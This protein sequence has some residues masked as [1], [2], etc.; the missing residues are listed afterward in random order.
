[1]RGTQNVDNKLAYEVISS[2]TST[3]SKTI[4]QAI[5]ELKTAFDTLTMEQKIHSAI[6]YGDLVLHIGDT[7]NGEFLTA[8]VGGNDVG[9]F[10]MRLSLGKYIMAGIN[11]NGTTYFNDLSSNVNYGTVKLILV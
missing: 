11:S 3:S 7:N 6:M 2:A 1:M 4:G 9:M 10:A 8:A 5:A